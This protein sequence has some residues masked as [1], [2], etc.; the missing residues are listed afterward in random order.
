VTRSR[1]ARILAA[2]FGFVG[3]AFLVVTFVRS[4]DATDAA[5]LP[6]FGSVAAAFVLA[7]LGLIFAGRGWTCL[8]PEEDGRLGLAGAF[9]ASQLG[10]YIPG[11]VW[12]AVGLVGLSNAE[13]VGFDHS[14]TVFPVHVVTQTVG[15]ALVGAGVVFL[16]TDGASALRIAALAGVLAPVFLYRGWM[17]ALL[18]RVG[19]WIGRDLQRH[20]PS[21][22]AILESFTWSMLTIVASGAAFAVLLRSMSADDSFAAAVVA[23]AFAW[24]VGFVALPFPA[25]LGVREAVLL[26]LLSTPAATVV[27]AAIVHRLVTIVAEVGAIAVSR[28]RILRRRRSAGP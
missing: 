3:A 7:E 9:Y 12:Q 14:G 25:G 27:S 10:K 24:V 6:D 16:D 18:S 22:R 11:G 13:G 28:L 26:A 17:R 4:L 23:F 15:V 20:L 19:T 5:V 8:F 21:Q 2:L 1:R